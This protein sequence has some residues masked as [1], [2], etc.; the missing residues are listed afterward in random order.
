MVETKLKLLLHIFYRQPLDESGTHRELGHSHPF[1]IVRRF[2]VLHSVSFFFVFPPKHFKLFI[3]LHFLILHQLVFIKLWKRF[4]DYTFAHCTRKNNEYYGMHIIPICYG[5][6]TN[7]GETYDIWAN[8]GFSNCCCWFRLIDF[9][10][11][12]DAQN[13]LVKPQMVFVVRTFKNEIL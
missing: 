4:G 9:D 2:Q 6:S 13:S 8:I 10:K 7:T 5:K 1:R 12:L 11:T 3:E